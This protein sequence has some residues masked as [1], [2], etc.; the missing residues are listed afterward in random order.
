MHNIIT[1][2]TTKICYY[3]TTQNAL[4]KTILMYINITISIDYNY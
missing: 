1:K 4:K 2:Y 3:V